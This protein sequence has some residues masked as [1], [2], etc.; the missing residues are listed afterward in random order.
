[1]KRILAAL[2]LSCAALG[3]ANAAAQQPSLTAGQ[4]KAGFL[5][6]FAAFVDWP[7]ST[8]TDAIV[9]GLLGGDEVEAELARIVAA[10]RAPG[11]SVT[12]RRLNPGEELAGIHILYVGAGESQRLERI[13]A[14]LRGTPT[15]VVSDTPEGLER[16]ATINFI[17]ADRVQFDISLESATRGGLRVSP[18]L[19]SVA[20]RVKKS[21]LTQEPVYA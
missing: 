9:I 12:M 20:V 18:R 14:A 11:R 1:M 6:H 15:L 16:G 5:Y 17:T 10:K 19:L 8:P 21:G 2:G 13:V 4:V 7:E 3:F